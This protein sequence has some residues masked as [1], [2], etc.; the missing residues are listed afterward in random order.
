MDRAD[1]IVIDISEAGPGS[2]WELDRL[3]TKNLT[4]RVVCVAVQGR[5]GVAQDVVSALLPAGF[6]DRFFGYRPDGAIP[7]A[8]EFLQMV[9][10]IAYPGTL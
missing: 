1:L 5:L 2:V 6:S 3:G 10:E 9:A 8:G 4:E 7:R